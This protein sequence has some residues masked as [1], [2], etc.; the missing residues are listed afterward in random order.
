M[1]Y[2]FPNSWLFL[3]V[4]TGNPDSTHF[5]M[6]H[7]TK[8]YPSPHLEHLRTYLSQCISQLLSL[9]FW[10][11]MLFCRFAHNG[12]FCTPSSITKK[13]AWCF[14]IWTLLRTEAPATT[15][16]P[17]LDQRHTHHWP[18]Q[19]KE[20][21]CLPEHQCERHDRLAFKAVP[22]VVGLLNPRMKMNQPCNYLRKGNLL[23]SLD[24][25]HASE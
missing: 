20:W 21:E 24:H 12:I 25:M 4:L 16:F 7:F 5:M 1:H 11:W 8:A 3:K 2:I 22:G 18:Y 23:D 9:A 19:S 10:C 6:V 15:K 17:V 13:P 14:V